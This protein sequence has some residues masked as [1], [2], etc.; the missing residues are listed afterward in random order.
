MAR[1]KQPEVRTNRRI[2]VPEVRLID[3]DGEQLGIVLTVDALG[4]AEEAGLDL[5]EVAPDARPPVCRLMDFGK[6]QYLQKKK[7][8]EARKKSTAS[9][10]KEIRLHPKTGER[11]VTVRIEQIR[12]FLA[13]R[14]KA[15]VLVVFRGREVVHPAVGR[16]HLDRIIRE[17]VETGQGVLEDAPRFEGKAMAMTLAPK[18]A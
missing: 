3:A 9:V 16:A 17:V 1:D 8:S 6:Y 15:R 18:G 10:V 5:V 13:D 7:T 14:N 12:R 4:R 11:D 2:R